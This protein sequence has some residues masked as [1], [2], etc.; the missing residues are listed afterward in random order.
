MQGSCSSFQFRGGPKAQACAS[1]STSTRIAS[2]RP[3]GA[4][5][6]QVNTPEV[7]LQAVDRQTLNLAT[8]RTRGHELIRAESVHRL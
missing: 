3:S 1:L 5:K 4:E 8:G 7:D 2:Q 6:R